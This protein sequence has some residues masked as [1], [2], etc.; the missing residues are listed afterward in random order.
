MTSSS[1]PSIWSS[2]KAVQAQQELFWMFII[3]TPLLKPT[4]MIRP[5]RYHW[6]WSHLCCTTLSVFPHLQLLIPEYSP[7]CLRYATIFAWYG[8]WQNIVPKGSRAVISYCCIQWLTLFGQLHDP[9]WIR[10]GSP[11]I[12]HTQDILLPCPKIKSS[13]CGASVLVLPFVLLMSNRGT[14]LC[15]FQHI[16]EPLHILQRIKFL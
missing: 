13:L 7:T 4:N 11:L 8:P 10:L 5:S 16:A 15:M 14:G 2:S 9:S 1:Y 12:F 6:Q 3:L